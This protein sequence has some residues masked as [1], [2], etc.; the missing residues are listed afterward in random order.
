[1]YR[2]LYYTILVLVLQFHSKKC[3]SSTAKDNVCSVDEFTC[4]AGRIKCVSI[5][6]IC[7]GIENCE[8]RS[9]EHHC[10]TC[11]G[12]HGNWF[13]C[14]NNKNDCIVSHWRCDGEQDCHDGSDELNCPIFSTQG[15]GCSES[16]FQCPNGMCIPIR[17]HCDGNFDC[18]DKSDE[19]ED[20]CKEKDTQKFSHSKMLSIRNRTSEININPQMYEDKFNSTVVKYF[21]E[22]T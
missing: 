7:D 3:L 15:N 17:W 16:E 22:L 19:N 11:G 13:Y 5:D 9:D 8:D 10:H 2:I 20:K 6:Q 4:S 21:F 14:G 12:P 18:I 1:M